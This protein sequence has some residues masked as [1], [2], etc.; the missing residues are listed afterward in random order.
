MKVGS[1]MIRGLMA[2]LVGL[3]L[4]A[5]SSRAGAAA[6]PS[7]PESI[8]GVGMEVIVAPG[9]GTLNVRALPARDTG[10]VG[11]LSAGMRLRV[12]GGRSCN[13]HYFWRRVEMANG[14][15]GWVAE[16]DWDGY[17]LIPTDGRRIPTPFAWTCPPARRCI[18]R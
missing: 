1:D 4:I 8:I 6:C 14:M 5:A 11:R 18:E 12:V 10:V 16:G 7:A 13:G 17:Y 2:G 15:R 9:I 3:A